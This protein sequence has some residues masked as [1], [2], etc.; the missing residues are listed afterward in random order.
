M[1]FLS[2]NSQ[3]SA[4][5]LVQLNS[6]LTQLGQDKRNL[7]SAQSRLVSVQKDLA[8]S[9]IDYKTAFDKIVPLTRHSHNRAISN[10]AAKVLASVLKPAQLNGAEAREAFNHANQTIESLISQ[11]DSQAESLSSLKNQ[12][13]KPRILRGQSTARLMS[14]VSQQV[15]ALRHKVIAQAPDLEIG[16]A[17]VM[18]QASKVSDQAF[19]MR[20]GFEEIRSPILARVSRMSRHHSSGF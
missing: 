19:K 3:K 6:S 7:L 16:V 14:N 17:K 13:S 12:I 20:E 15:D 18:I 10:A 4:H 9:L 2:V 11:I 8:N 5:Q 1:G